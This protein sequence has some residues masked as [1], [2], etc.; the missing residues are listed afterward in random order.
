MEPENFESYLTAEELE[1]YKQ[2]LIARDCP[3]SYEDFVQRCTKDNVV[4]G[5]FPWS[6]TSEGHRYW[7]K[8]NER[9]VNNMPLPQPDE[10]EDVF[11]VPKGVDFMQFFTAEQW[12][13]LTEIA[14][15]FMGVKEYQHWMNS[16]YTNLGSFIYSGIP[17]KDHALFIQ[18]M[19]MAESPSY[20]KSRGY[21]VT[22]GEFMTKKPPFTDY[23]YI[24]PVA[25]KT[26]DSG[27]QSYTWSE[28]FM[29]KMTAQAYAQIQKL[30]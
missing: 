23:G 25:D 2:N 12:K 9:I 11:E 22:P 18:N 4:K 16:Y 3:W 19:R 29:L 26:T 21:V 24:M 1:N 8:I 15:E 6:E 28:E 27:A 13:E 14:M 10:S 5:A 17:A 30:L 7:F 20:R